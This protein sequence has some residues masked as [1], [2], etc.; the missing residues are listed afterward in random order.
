ML[1]FYHLKGLTIPDI[2]QDLSTSHSCPLANTQVNPLLILLRL[3][4]AR[5]AATDTQC[6]AIV[7]QIGVKETRK[8]REWKCHGSCPY[9]ICV[10]FL[11]F[12]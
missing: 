2:M 11:L 9:L 5:L 7:Q 1:R 12:H 6:A 10:P 3:E 4:S 8:W